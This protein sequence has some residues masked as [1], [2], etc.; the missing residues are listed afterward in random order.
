M[1]KKENKSSV[2]YKQL[3][4]VVLKHSE[5]PVWHKHFNHFES[6]KKKG[7][8]WESITK[9]L[10]E[11]YNIN[12]TTDQVRKAFVANQKKKKAKEDFEPYY[13]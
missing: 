6:L 2:N 10:N 1:T 4:S 3:E 7:A 13:R 5:I 9:G 11:I 12:L 8:T